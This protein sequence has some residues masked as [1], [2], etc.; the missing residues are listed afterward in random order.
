M[1]FLR[2]KGV[3]ISSV[4]LTKEGDPLARVDNSTLAAGDKLVVNF[5]EN[6]SLHNSLGLGN[7]LPAEVLKVRVNGI[8]GIRKNSPKPGYYSQN[9]NGKSLYLPVYNGDK[10][11]IL[12]TGTL[13]VEDKALASEADRLRFR[14]ERI[15]DMVRA[16]RENGDNWKSQ[17]STLPEDAELMEEAILEKE[18]E[19]KRKSYQERTYG[20]IN[21]REG[22]LAYFA[23]SMN[24]VTK[25]FG[26]P[27]TVLLKLFEKES[28]FSTTAMSPAGAYGLG[29]IKPDT[30]SELNNKIIPAQGLISGPLTADDP[31][32]QIKAACAYLKFARDEG[33]KYFGREISWADSFLLYHGGPNV[34]NWNIQ[35]YLDANPGIGKYF[36]GELTAEN[37]MKA[38]SKYYELDGMQ[39]A[40]WEA[41]PPSTRSLEW[42]KFEGYPME[43]SNDGMTYCSRTA[44]LNASVFG[45]S[46]P[47]AESAKKSREQYGSEAFFADASQI[48]AGS[49]VADVFLSSTTKNGSIHGHRALALR[50][51]HDG[52]WYILDP[53]Y[54]SQSNP[55]SLKEYQNIYSSRN[56]GKIEAF[57]PYKA[58]GYASKLL[59]A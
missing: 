47:R 32:D 30:L 44:A 8:E 45:I 38:A 57:Y 53:Y 7:I 43:K 52:E 36:T 1:L 6:K 31:V 33:K 29:Q 19:E 14:Q 37:Y 23:D 55:I 59:S 34:A 25:I 22:F 5:G 21:S 9:P 15:R 28:G 39:T 3:D 35:K 2:Q 12:A 49:N 13:S 56:G 17:F 20:K 11:E 58:H 41:L 16:M 26:I 10:V 42:D 27:P 48:P 54:T 4:L 18:N 50:A 51:K 24:D 40:I 46:V